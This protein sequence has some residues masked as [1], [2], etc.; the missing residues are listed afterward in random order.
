MYETTSHTARY[1]PVSTRI[2]RIQNE[3]LHQIRRNVCLSYD[4]DPRFTR[5]HQDKQIYSALNF[6]FSLFKQRRINAQKS[7]INPICSWYCL[8]AMILI[9]DNNPSYL[10]RASQ[11]KH[12]IT[13]QPQITHKRTIMTNFT[14]SHFP[15]YWSRN[16]IAL[17]LQRH[18]TIMINKP[19]LQK[20]YR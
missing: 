4:N 17:V 8:L 3:D 14:I 20:H 1:I 13:W 19:R 12:I 7:S 9:K 16:I 2:K 10:T 18:G 11:L 6:H 5:W 15:G